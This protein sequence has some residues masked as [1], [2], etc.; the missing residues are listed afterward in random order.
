[1]REF[2]ILA[3]LY[4]VTVSVILG[5]YWI[6]GYN[7]NA[8]VFIFLPTVVMAGAFSV[9]FAFALFSFF[10]E[11]Y[12]VQDFLRRVLPKI[13]E[14][15]VFAYV[16]FT[17]TPAMIVLV[18]EL[19]GMLKQA[20]K[21][22]LPVT[23]YEVK[24]GEVKVWSGDKGPYVIDSLK[25]WSLEKLNDPCFKSFFYIKKIKDSDIDLEKGIIMHF[26]SVLL[27]INK[28]KPAYMIKSCKNESSE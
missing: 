26:E 6:V 20:D 24:N 1:M 3:L 8:G 2:K 23:A 22:K 17:F 27:D 16:F 7:S 13:K 18:L 25:E 9:F 5:A 19:S 11:N 28:T 15:G 21:V 12:D 14:P 4:F 10:N